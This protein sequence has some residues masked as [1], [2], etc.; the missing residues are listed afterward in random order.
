MLSSINNINKKAGI[1]KCLLWIYKTIVYGSFT[2]MFTFLIEM[3]IMS[4]DNDEPVSIK[5]VYITP[6]VKAGDYVRLYYSGVVRYRQCAVER[7]AVI[8]YSSGKKVSFET[9]SSND[10]GDVGIVPDGVIEFKT[11][12]EAETGLASLST[13]TKW[14]CLGN[15]Y[16]QFYP[17]E[18]TTRYNFNVI[19]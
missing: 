17:I 9:N 16:H 1:L 8:V 4:F 5:Y 13:T 3:S 7:Q 14:K 19:N 18:R 15:I 6:I 12:D 2:L 10:F 11:A